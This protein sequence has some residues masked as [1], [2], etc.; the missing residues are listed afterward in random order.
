MEKKLKSLIRSIIVSLSFALLLCAPAYAKSGVR[1]PSVRQIT[2][3][4]PYRTGFRASWVRKKPDAKY[5]Q[6]QYCTQP[7]F[8]RKVKTVRTRVDSSTAK[9]LKVRVLDLKGGQK[10]YLRLRSY[11]KVKGKKYYSKWSRKKSVKLPILSVTLRV[12]H[13]D[14]IL[15]ERALKP[16]EN[17]AVTLPGIPDGVWTDGDSLLY[18]TTGADESVLYPGDVL[19]AE[20]STLDLFTVCE[21]SLVTGN[22]ARMNHVFTE[23]YEKTEYTPL[24]YST[25]GGTLVDK[26][27]ETYWVQAAVRLINNAEMVEENEVAG[28]M[29]YTVL[30]IYDFETG[31]LLNSVFNIPF[32]HAND[33]DYNPYTDRIII[34]SE[35]TFITEVDWDLEH[36]QIITPEGLDNERLV[37]CAYDRD[38]RTYLANCLPFGMKN[39]MENYSCAARYD[40][41]WHLIERT[42]NPYA[43]AN[44]LGVVN[45]YGFQG[46]CIDKGHFYLVNFLNRNRQEDG[47]HSYH[48]GRI[49]V[50]DSGTLAYE[51]SFF[52]N[53]GQA[54]ELEDV[55]V[56]GSLMLLCGQ[57]H[58]VNGYQ[59]YNVYDLLLSR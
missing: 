39:F 50:F 15:F 13:K 48:Y 25:Q 16:D 31:E 57:A 54:D 59:K 51:G 46:T 14:E 21:P 4:Q 42:G 28:P 47:E 2:D 56:S 32:G 34:C 44:H 23:E 11:K 24:R 30:F 8:S 33:L 49:S 29:N 5:Y 17:G 6:L 10:Y 20:Q 53:L 40:E 3:V 18:Y 55:V 43:R 41:D 12:W 38:S 27:G 1:A 7:D 58:K 35:D 9:M 52:V 45:R 22:R 36:Y 37:T 26:D 19:A